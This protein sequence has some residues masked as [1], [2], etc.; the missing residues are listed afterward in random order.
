MKGRTHLA[1]GLGIG[2]IA[3]IG[4]SPETI[5]AIVIISG[6]ASL[7]PDLDGNN[8]LNKRVTKTAKK[9]KKFG[10]I[11][12]LMFMVLS[13]LAFF[14]DSFSIL[15]ERWFTSQNKIFVLVIGAVLAG[16]SLR[17]QETVKNILMS[18]FGL[19]LIYYGATHHLWWLVLF[20]LYIGVAGWFAHRGPTHTLWA[21]IYWGW[22]S[23]LLE[24]NTEIQGITLISCVS[25]LSHI[26]GDMLTKRGI[27]FF[28]PLSDRVFRLRFLI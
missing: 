25:Y 27:K 23:Y 14:W 24:V 2:A 20:A 3:A 26:I 9:I 13:L 28:K 12:G 21:V 6:I 5:P 4:R 17:A 7:A 16:I 22:M 10:L 19:P 18:L 8:L 1:V 11:V 15:N